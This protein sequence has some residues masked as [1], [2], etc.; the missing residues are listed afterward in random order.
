MG[1]TG[2]LLAAGQGK[3][4]S[5]YSSH[6]KALVPV[7][8]KPLI[9]Y[10]LDM[11]IAAGVERIVVVIG[12]R[13]EEVVKHLSGTAY[14]GRLEYV[15]QEK[16]LGTGDAVKIAQK[17]L[18]SK[19][20]VLCYC[21]NFTGYELKKLISR[22]REGGKVVT[23]GL[24]HAANP[25]RHGIMEVVDGRVV[26]LEERPEH[27]KSDLAF[28]GIGCFEREI[29]EAVS[30]VKISAKGEYY[31]TDA[32]MDLIRQG[33]QVGYAEVDSY[34]VNINTPEDVIAAEKFVRGN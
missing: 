31:L 3:R 2:L 18:E 21:D 34:R 23:L 5:G 4:I 10:N 6:P 9:E 20:F 11:M 15:K 12:H 1:L 30:Q 7:N 19:P 27:P 28:A 26:N 29:Y 14:A 24:F 16:Q 17:A 13:G 8:G 22:H 25:S 33:K 32:V